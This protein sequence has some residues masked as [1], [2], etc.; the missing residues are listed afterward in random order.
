M[1][2]TETGAGSD[3]VARLAERVV[4]STLA[5]G[6]SLA[7]A[8]SL[9]GGLVCAALAS[10]PGVS[11]VLRG[12]VVAYTDQVKIALLDVEAD[13]LAR[14]GAVHEDV[15]V[16]MA[17]GARR[18]LGAELGLATTGVAG[19]GPHGGLPAG[20]VVVA[21]SAGM[22]VTVRRLSLP[23]DR[24]DVRRASAAAVLRLALDDLDSRPS[25]R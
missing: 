10:V 3:D 20:T 12:G 22:A 15:A 14:R 13:L 18:R 25:R 17:H 21:V 1:E 11:A 24:T 6:I 2:P 23:G 7:T 8:E 9:T 19:P 5:E 16:Q 4:A